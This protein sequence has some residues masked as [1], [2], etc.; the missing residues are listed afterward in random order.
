[1]GFC[2]ISALGHILEILEHCGMICGTLGEIIKIIV[3]K[4]TQVDT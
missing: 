2:T 1:M 3:E 4:I